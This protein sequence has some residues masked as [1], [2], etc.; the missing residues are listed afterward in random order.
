M[1]ERELS[2]G[3]NKIVFDDENPRITLD[4]AVRVANREIVYRMEEFG[5]VEEGNVI[6]PYRVPTIYNIREWLTEHAND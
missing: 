6:R 1:V 3:W 5:Y 2:N 4:N